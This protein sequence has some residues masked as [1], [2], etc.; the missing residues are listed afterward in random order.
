MDR[1][2]LPEYSAPQRLC[3]YCRKLESTSQPCPVVA[4]YM[5]ATKHRSSTTATLF[6]SGTGVSID[7]HKLLVLLQN[8]P[9]S[10][11]NRCAAYNVINV[12]RKSQPRDMMQG[13]STRDPAFYTQES[14]RYIDLMTPYRLHLGKP[15]SIL[16]TPSCQF[17]RLLYCILPRDLNAAERDV[18]V[19]PFRSH[20]RQE[21]WEIFP[22]EMRSRTAVFLGLADVWSPFTPVSDPFRSGEDI[23]RFPMMTGPALSLD[24]K[25]A[26]PDRIYNNAKALTSMLDL[27]LLLQPLEHCQEHHG[28]VCFAIRPPELL[29]TRMIDVHRREVVPC[30]VE[31]DYVALSYVW[32]GVQPAVNALRDR[33]LPNTIEDA[34]T[35]TKALGRRYLWVDALCIDQSPNPSPEVLKEK[36]QQLGMMATIY[37]CATVTMVALTGTNANAGLAGVSV[38]R[39]HQIVET[40]EEHQVFT[41]PQYI[42]AER[43]ASA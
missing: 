27:S 34:I 21:G 7:D 5:N 20:I 24:T 4:K 31:C 41:V 40:I 14:Q 39:P 2:A 42:S 17:C 3:I 8:H 18:H 28:D 25:S 33:C 11:C 22:N 16:L 9:S 1:M 10:L 43:E 23:I 35:V 38:S 29:T 6:G 37:G 30:P 36:I 12:F 15:P 13:A 26:L 32:G 19:E